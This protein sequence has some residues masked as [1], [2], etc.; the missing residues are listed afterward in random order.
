M[1]EKS[2]AARTH[3]P[4]PQLSTRPAEEVCKELNDAGIPASIKDGA[5]HFLGKKVAVAAINDA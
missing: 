1:A 2:S 3:L 5:L 4:I